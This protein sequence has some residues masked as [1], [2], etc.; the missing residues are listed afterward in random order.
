MRINASCISTPKN[1]ILTVLLMATS[2]LIAGGF[3]T[4][5]GVTLISENFSSYTTATTYTSNTNLSS[6][7]H[8]V[9]NSSSG[10]SAN[11]STSGIAFTD[12][13]TTVKYNAAMFDFASTVSTT[14]TGNNLLSGSFVLTKT[15]SSGPDFAFGLNT[16]TSYANPWLS[17]SCT[18][19]GFVVFGTGRVSYY[20]TTGALSASL[21]TLSAGTSYKFVI[22]ADYSSS[23]QDT[24]SFSI[25]DLSSGLTV[26]SSPTLNTWLANGVATNL[27]FTAGNNGTAA[28]ADPY[29][30]L[31]DIQ[32][33]AVPEPTTVACLLFGAILLGCSFARAK[34]NA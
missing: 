15:S 21:Y 12:N 24:Y 8:L 9:I 5:H 27:I 19:A 6:T 33:T 1:K 13:S 14:N 17:S 20:T 16:G 31:S 26:Y 34:R 3:S 18:T 32:F 4:V 29:I 2:W 7:T 30:T 11:V 28:S 23:T 10:E 22:N 25:I